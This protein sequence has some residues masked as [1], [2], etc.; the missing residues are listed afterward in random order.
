MT[1]VM[2]KKPQ[3]SSGFS[4]RGTLPIRK[5][6]GL[7]NEATRAVPN[8]R[9]PHGAPYLVTALESLLGLKV[10]SRA[11]ARKLLTE[12]PAAEQLELL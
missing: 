10:A 12:L 3:K 8:Y 6:I 9:T 11:P 4:P 2:P 1:S 7:H 5:L